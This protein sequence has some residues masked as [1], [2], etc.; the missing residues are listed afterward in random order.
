MS[1]NDRTNIERRANKKKHTESFY[2]S[3]SGC[4]SV[5]ISTEK[6]RIKTT[7]STKD[8]EQ[9]K[10]KHAVCDVRGQK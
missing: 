9:G 7:N 3:V 8:G 6:K 5:F 4:P 2:Q 1:E 10:K